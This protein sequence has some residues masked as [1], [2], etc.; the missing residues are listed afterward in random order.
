MGHARNLWPRP[1]PF[2]FVWFSSHAIYMVCCWFSF[3]TVWLWFG[4]FGWL[5]LVGVARTDIHHPWQADTSVE[6][7]LDPCGALVSSSS[8]ALRL[9]PASNARRSV[10]WFRTQ[11]SHLSLACPWHPLSV[12]PTRSLIQHSQTHLRGSHTR[13]FHPIHSFTLFLF[14]FLFP[15]FVVGIVPPFS[16]LFPFVF[17]G[18]D[19]SPPLPPRDV[20]E[21]I[22]DRTR[23]GW[24]TPLGGTKPT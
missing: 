17:V 20:W 12:C 7:V 19:P 6:R 21:G 14:L 15:P 4:R 5:G 13:S 3:R 16:F 11:R 18:L 9:P 8:P 2:F 1:V 23:R 24:N 22:E 10:P